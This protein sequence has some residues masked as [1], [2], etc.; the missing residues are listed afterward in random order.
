VMIV[1]TMVA[2]QIFK[3]IEA[4]DLLGVKTMLIGIR[5]EVAQTMIQ[6]GINF[7]KLTVKSNLEQALLSLN[8]TIDTLE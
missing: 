2:H 1:D 7:S 6:L 3:I 8:L 5:P 4:L